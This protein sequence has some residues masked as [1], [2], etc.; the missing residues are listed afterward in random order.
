MTKEDEDAAEKVLDE[1][2]NLLNAAGYSEVIIVTCKDIKNEKG[3]SGT[4]FSLVVD[5]YQE[6]LHESIGML[7]EVFESP[8]FDKPTYMLQ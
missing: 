1:A 4:T 5:A 7:I 3:N 6:T 2:K 8:N